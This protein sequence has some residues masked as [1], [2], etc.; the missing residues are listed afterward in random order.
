MANPSLRQDRH[1]KIAALTGLPMAGIGFDQLCTGDVRNCSFNL[2][3]IVRET[4]INLIKQKLATQLEDTVNDLEIGSGRTIDK[5]Y[6]G[7]TH[8]QRKKRSSGNREKYVRF[9]PCDSTTWRIGGI[10]SC[11]D[12]HKQQDCDYGK[13]GLVVLGAITKQTV[14]GKLR[15]RVQQEDFALAMEEML[16]HHFYFFDHDPR[17]VRDTFSNCEN[18]HHAYAIY[19][20]FRYDD[21]VPTSDESMELDEQPTKRSS[22]RKNPTPES[23][24]VKKM[25]HT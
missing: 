25:K 9:S 23:S 7:K 6:I 5:I 15:D 24:P 4:D 19:M 11:W 17:V 14:P 1:F 8:I 21:E 18:S 16:Y 3:D 12:H 2:T 22:P 20:A 13:D 10:S